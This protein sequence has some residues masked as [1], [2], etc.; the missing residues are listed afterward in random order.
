MP[1]APLRT[2]SG[3]ANCRNLVAKGRCATCSS[4][5]EQHRGSRHARGYNAAWVR[6]VEEFWADPAH[7]FCVRCALRGRQELAREVDH[8][9]PFKGLDDPLR[10]DRTNLQGLC[11][12]C[13]R[14][15]TAEQQRP[16]VV[17]N[18][19][20]DCK[21]TCPSLVDGSVRRPSTLGPSR[22]VHTSAVDDIGRR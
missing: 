12:L 19:Q 8:V 20:M 4:K 14:Q 22:T 9:V 5:R 13:H 7:R 10:L 1:T 6:L 16:V 18:G 15:K 11:G 21:G 17:W 3:S 2:C